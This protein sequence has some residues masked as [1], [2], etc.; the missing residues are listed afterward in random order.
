MKESE[1]CY[2]NVTPAVSSANVSETEESSALHRVKVR[3]QVGVLLKAFI[4]FR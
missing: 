4:C 3:I 2:G 1:T